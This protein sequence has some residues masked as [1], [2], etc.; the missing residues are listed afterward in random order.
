MGKYCVRCGYTTPDGW[1]DECPFCL[2]TMAR[3]GRPA[4]GPRLPIPS[5]VRSFRR[6]PMKLLIP[7]V[8]LVGAVIV[9]SATGAFMLVADD[10]ALGPPGDSD[11]TGRI[12][13]GMTV[14]RVGEILGM[15]RPA[16]DRTEDG[17][18]DPNFTGRFVWEKNGRLVR[19]TFEHG[20]VSAVE[21][22]RPLV[23]GRE[24]AEIHYDN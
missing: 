21:E 22:G 12:R 6:P 14:D 10:M 24:R 23:R 5:P 18:P 16:L 4:V 13:T 2:V 20:H 8:L 17:Q 19:V 9:G 11:L 15:D 1:A 7:L 3:T